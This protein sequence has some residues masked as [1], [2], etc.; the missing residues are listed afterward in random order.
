VI[1]YL[2][3]SRSAGLRRKVKSVLALGLPL[4]SAKGNAKLIAIGS[5]SQRVATKR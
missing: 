2:S 3:G 5:S 1:S 4:I